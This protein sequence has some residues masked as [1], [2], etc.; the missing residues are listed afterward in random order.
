MKLLILLL[1]LIA[2]I[3]NA[4]AEAYVDPS[5]CYKAEPAIGRSA[6]PT[7]FQYVETFCISDV[8]WY[9]ER[10]GVRFNFTISFENNYSES[11]PFG[12]RQSGPFKVSQLLPRKALQGGFGWMLISNHDSGY[13][14][15]KPPESSLK[16]SVDFDL[17]V[18]GIGTPNLVFVGASQ[19]TQRYAIETTHRGTWRL[20]YRP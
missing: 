11:W 2:P 13:S 17:R 14:D 18:G 16:C 10:N 15:C 19:L 7:Y 6:P 4:K 20:A 3:E 1:L 8:E 12:R 5:N 9:E